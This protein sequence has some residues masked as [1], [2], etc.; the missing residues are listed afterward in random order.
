MII[1]ILRIIRLKKRLPKRIYIYEITYIRLQ[2]FLALVVFYLFIS[3]NAYLYSKYLKKVAS[4][5]IIDNG[6]VV[7]EKSEPLEVK[8]S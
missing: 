3:Y 2:I 6:D 4:D 5:Q 7:L 1:S 8:H